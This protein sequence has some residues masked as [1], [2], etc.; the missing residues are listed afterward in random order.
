M[1]SRPETIAAILDTLPGATAR[2]MFG[3]YALYFDGKVVA[4]VCDDSLFVKDL[5]PARALLPDAPLGAPYPGR[6]RIWWPMAG[7]TTPKP[8]APPSAPSPRRCRRP[9]R[10]SRGRGARRI[11][12]RP[13]H[14]ASTR[15]GSAHTGRA[16]EA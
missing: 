10:K 6:N 13:A 8:W 16:F 12:I 7:W 4:L 11:D 3:E 9:S 14:D 2:K 15:V 1:A 5:P